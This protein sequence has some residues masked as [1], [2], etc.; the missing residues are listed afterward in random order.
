MRNPKTLLL[1]ILL[2]SSSGIQAQ[3]DTLFSEFLSLFPGG[4]LESKYLS[5]F[6][7]F[8]D[9]NLE[10]QMKHQTLT[11]NEIVRETDNFILLSVDME[12]GA[13]GICE[14]TFLYTLTKSGEL[15][16]TIRHSGGVGDCGFRNI[17]TAVIFNDTLLVTHYNKWKGDCME[18][19]TEFQTSIIHENKI[20]ENGNFKHIRSFKIDLRRKYSF[21]S[22]ELLNVKNLNYK[23]DEL[24]AI[25]NEIFASYGYTFKSERWRSYFEQQDWYSP[26]A[27][28][29]DESQFSIIE[30]QNLELIK[31]LE[32]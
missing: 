28:S 5:K 18:D 15:I 14:G 22:T 30:N 10:Q 21:V 6:L 11:A 2:V 8:E 32:H 12:C 19:T 1:A 3:T 31:Q 25:R 29:L 7:G 17:E 20:D 13:G 23:S 26:T 4:Q 9:P 24:A 27:N 16:S